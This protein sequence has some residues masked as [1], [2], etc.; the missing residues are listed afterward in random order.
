MHTGISQKNI[1]S[2]ILLQKQL[3]HLLLV[4]KSYI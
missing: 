1:N 3:L 4:S 2:I